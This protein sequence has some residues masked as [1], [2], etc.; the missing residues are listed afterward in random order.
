[1]RGM[2]RTFEPRCHLLLSRGIGHAATAARVTIPL[3]ALTAVTLL[4]GVNA[5]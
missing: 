1:M 4:T 3:V 2:A 5:P